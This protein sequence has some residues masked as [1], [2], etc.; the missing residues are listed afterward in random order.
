MCLLW[1]TSC[2][3]K[4]ACSAF[5]ACVCHICALPSPPLH[6]KFHSKNWILARTN[7]YKS[8]SQC[9]NVATSAPKHDTSTSFW[10]SDRLHLKPNY[11]FWMN[12]FRVMFYINYLE[13]KYVY[14][15]KVK[16]ILSSWMEHTFAA[17]ALNHWITSTHNCDV[18]SPSDYSIMQLIS[19][20][21]L[22]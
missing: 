9:S 16:K 2:R 7:T 18:V 11:P 1:W 22:Y 5:V 13:E 3:A 4:F 15:R 10:S 14:R 12:E 20:T 19:I 21:S 17:W 6:H 8:M